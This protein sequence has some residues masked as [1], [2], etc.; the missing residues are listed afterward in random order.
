VTG[1][2]IVLATCAAWPEV[3]A[4]DAR[5]AAALEARGR[6]VTAAPWNGPFAPFAEAAAVVIRS[7]WDYHEAPGDYL[8]WLARLDAARTLNPPSLVR[9]NLSKAHILDLGA[10]GVRVPR[11]LEAEATPVALAGALARL[12]L[13]EAVI[14]PLIGGSGFG[15]ERVRRGGEA[16]ALG[17]AL[18]HKPTERLLVQ[19][20]LPGIERGELAGVFFDGVFSHGL[21]R[22]PAAGEFRVNS[23]YGGRMEADAL[24]SPTI[25][26]MSRVLRTLPTAPLYARID[27]VRRDGRFVLMEVEVNEPG[28]G[29]HLAPGS[30]DR[31]A[32]ALVARV[33]AA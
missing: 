25:E 10:R 4:S 29:L 22:V 31:F 28:L 9:W 5:L 20:W 32:E 13:D 19:E 3:S 14:K 17:R 26:A 21:R 12:S 15:V 24:D 18:A 7:T 27:G 11:S 16:A 1:V 8:A 23:Q 2:P 6:R 30:A 33:R